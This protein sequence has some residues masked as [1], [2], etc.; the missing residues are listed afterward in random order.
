MGRHARKASPSSGR[1]AASPRI[2]SRAGLRGVCCSSRPSRACESFAS[3]LYVWACTAAHTFPDFS[4][5]PLEGTNLPSLSGDL[6]VGLPV[7]ATS[8]KR[9][10]EVPCSSSSQWKS[11]V[12]QFPDVLAR[13]ESSFQP[14]LSLPCLGA[15]E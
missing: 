3:I 4:L 7:W 11:S 9:G 8:P 2:T 1:W 15:C 6:G 10:Q 5:G 12:S 13:K 14:F